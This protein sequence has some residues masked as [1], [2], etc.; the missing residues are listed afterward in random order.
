MTYKPCLME[1]I[2]LISDINA[3]NL[4]P[5]PPEVRFVAQAALFEIPKV[6]D[7]DMFAHNLKESLREVSE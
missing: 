1:L 5:A 4:P 3:R 2:S 7:L 6:K